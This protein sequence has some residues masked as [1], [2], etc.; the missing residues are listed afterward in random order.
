MILK[1]PTKWDAAWLQSNIVNKRFMSSSSNNNK[2]SGTGYIYSIQ[3]PID[4]IKYKPI[5]L[6]V[7]RITNENW[8]GYKTTLSPRN[9][10]ICCVHSYVM[11]EGWDDNDDCV[12][13]IRFS[14]KSP[15]R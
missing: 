12:V 13:A 1:R 3:I 14:H 5:V 15:T 9:S 11:D 2:S 6:Y 4:D 10:V 7:K 8:H